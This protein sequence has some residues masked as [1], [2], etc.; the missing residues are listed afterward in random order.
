[1]AANKHSKR[2]TAD[3]T[4][5]GRHT[6]DTTDQAVPDEPSASA[7][8]TPVETAEAASAPT[9]EAKTADTPMPAEG[10]TSQPDPTVPNQ[11][12]P[13]KKRSALDAAAKVLGETGQAMNC[14]ELIAAMAAQGYWSSPKGRTPASTLYAALL[15][16]LKTKG[17]KARFIKTARGKFLLKG[18]R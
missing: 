12:T 14:P 9:A 18:A 15:R 1:M 2:T 3:K 17:E 10:E 6:T 5:K 8:R 16:E 4:L 7:E 11:P 13:G